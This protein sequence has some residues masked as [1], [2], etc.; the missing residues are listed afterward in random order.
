M[1]VNLLKR[2]QH[3]RDGQYIWPPIADRLMHRV[4]HHHLVTLAWKKTSEH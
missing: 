3:E 1:L 4:S 2:D